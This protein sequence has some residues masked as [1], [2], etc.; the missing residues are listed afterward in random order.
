MTSLQRCPKC[1]EPNTPDATQCAACH[2]PLV[3]QCPHCG[4]TR[5]WYVTRCPQ[6]DSQAEDA[7]AFTE[8]FQKKPQRTLKGRYVIQETISTSRVSSVYIAIARNDASQRYAI[9]ELSPIALFRADERREAQSML[10]TTLERWARLQHA[11]LPRLI[12]SFTDKD[13]VYVVMEFVEG[14]SGARIITERLIVTPELASNWGYQ[15]CELF[16]YLH[17]QKPDLH[18]PFLAPQH[19]MVDLEGRVK[20]IDWGLTAIF[21]PTTY[22]P[23]G[24]IKGYGAPELQ[25]NPPTPESDVFALARLLYALLSGQLLQKGVGHPVPLQRAV[26]GISSTLVKAIAQAASRGPDTRP[27]VAAFQRVLEQNAGETRLIPNWIAFRP[28]PQAATPLPQSRRERSTPRSAPKRTQAATMADL[29]FERDPRFGPEAD[30]PVEPAIRRMDAAESTAQRVEAAAPRLSVHPH[31]FQ[32][33]DL[34]PGTVKRLV[35]N[36]RNIGQ[37]E[38]NG[39]IVSHV[40]WLRAPRKPFQLPADKQAKV[41]VS[42]RAADLPGGRTAEPQAISVDTNG[43]RQWIAVQ[44]EVASGPILRIEQPFLDFGTFEHDNEQNARLVISNGGRETL[45][46][47]V[48]SRVPWL[49][50][51]QSEFRCP[52]GS[53]I[54][55]GVRLLPSRLPR[56]G[57]SI[58]DALVIDSDGGQAR[59]QVTAWRL[60]PELAIS[61]SRIDLGT[62][63]SGDV[64]E[65]RVEASNVGDG[66]LQATIQSHIPWLQVEPAQLTL[67]PGQRAVFAIRADTAN[68]PDGSVDVPQAARI[69]SNGGNTTLSMRAHIQ[70]PHMVLETVSLDLGAVPLGEQATGSLAISN[71]GSATLHAIVEPMVS[72]ISVAQH[73]VVCPPNK[74]VIIPVG[75]D[76]TPFDRGQLLS[77]PEAL[78]VTAGSVVQYIGARVAILHPALRVEPE[79][80]DFGYLIPTEPGYATVQISNE[81]TGSLAW[82]AQT[83]AIW[84][85]IEPPSGVCASG[86]SQEVRLTAYA[87]ALD[88]DTEVTRSTLI[89]NSDGGRAKIALQAGLASPQLAVDTAMLALGPSINR[90]PVGGSFRIFNRGLGLLRGTITTDQTWIVPARASFECPMGRSLE[91]GV[92]VDMEE[93]PHTSAHHAGTIRVESNGGTREIEVEL[94]ILLAPDIEAANSELALGQGEPDSLLQE[95]LVIRNEGQATAHCELRGSVPQLVFSRN[96]IDIKPEKSVRVTVRWQGALPDEATGDLYVEVLSDEKTLRIPVSLSLN[97]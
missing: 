50:V 34:K 66:Q 63:L 38:L 45:T 89:I 40:D 81:G 3:H 80:V 8:L 9:K 23:Y 16:T 47:R 22:G 54:Q 74:E 95:R 25:T 87:L 48:L 88:N 41:I 18:V 15:L 90:K 1:N 52:G 79:Q 61:T 39:Q 73:D 60:V 70:A 19:I 69:F 42:V 4:R 62:V 71:T 93:L 97:S 83:S 65:Q 36:I 51:P 12:D 26:P 43:G 72:W 31:S 7:T 2:A 29:G 96:L 64:V 78:R 75:V 77:A 21:T 59:V 35:L 68:L 94:E 92:V 91:I 17:G 32:L 49:Q 55:V 84:L 13:K 37:A 53:S 85:E 33:T 82:N 10:D 24:S 5:P 58:V 57:Q 6:C 56:G 14:W 44:A 20:L 27:D 11:N 76:T 86:A 28:A 46:G 67:A 30:R